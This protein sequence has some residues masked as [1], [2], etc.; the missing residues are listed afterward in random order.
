MI[1]PDFPLSEFLQSRAQAGQEGRL[2][3]S[4]EGKEGEI[5]LT[6]GNVAHARCGKIRG[7]AAFHILLKLGS[8]DC[9]WFKG[10]SPQKSTFFKPVDTLLVDHAFIE[11][12]SDEEI[13]SQF[14]AD[15]L[16]EDDEDVTH[17]FSI[18]VAGE[19]LEAFRFDM[20]IS[21]V[22]VGR[23]PGLT[24]ICV[25][26]SSVSGLHGMLI[27]AGDKVLYR[28]L[29]S[30]N[31]SWMDGVQ[32]R[33][34]ELEPG[35]TIH[36]GMVAVELH[37]FDPGRFA[38]YAPE[39]RSLEEYLSVQKVSVQPTSGELKEAA[40]SGKKRSTAKID[41]PFSSSQNT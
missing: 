31:G 25:P 6:A 39:G 11:T 18:F 23:N 37:D 19:E 20:D 26:D 16:G 2:V 30:T 10:E 41:V 29:G 12:M 4:G 3:V 1:I 27:R 24:N 38:S 13:C 15:P 33:E 40:S 21:Q 14:G 36:L 28:D 32:I 7:E 9:E 34:V 22:I 17:V 35:H 5:F 8:A